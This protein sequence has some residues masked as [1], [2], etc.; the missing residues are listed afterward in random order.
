MPDTRRF[1][2]FDLGAESGRCVVATLSGGK[3]GLSEVHRFPT[4]S[5][6]H[7]DGLHWDI[8]AIASDIVAGL[9][10]A[11]REFGPDFAGI[12]ADTWGVDYVLLDS[13]GRVL[14][15]PYHYRDSRTDGIMDEAFAV[16][17]KGRLYGATGTQFAQFNTVFQ[18]LA[19][20]RRSPN[21]L[22]A[23]AT[24]L[25]MPDYLN[26][27][28][29]GEARAE[30]TIASTT[31][32]A[33]PTTRQWAWELIDS[34]SLPRAIFP[35]VVEPGTVLGA[36]R[37]DLAR[38]T[39]VNPGTPVIATAGHD[40]AS[41]VASIPASGD[42]WA[43]LSSGTWSLFGVE[44]PAPVMTDEAMRRDFTNE[45]GVG[46]TTRFLKNII[47]LWPIQECRRA[48]R[49]EGREFT[50][51]QLGDLARGEGSVGA[52][53][54]LNDPRFLKPGDMPRKIDSYLQETGQRRQENVGF[55]VGV[56]LESLAFSYRTAMKDLEAVTGRRI[57]RLHAVGG[58]IQNTLL[59]GMT[60]DA[61]GLP[62]LAGPVEGTIVG[63]IGMQAVATGAVAS[64]QAWRDIVSASFRLEQYGPAHTA[65][66]DE[67]EGRYLQAIGLA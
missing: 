20:R 41:A 22:D 31:G 5:V 1:I 37:P 43:Y 8:H 42:R 57:E 48:W 66:F 61:L 26:Y 46:G 64:P 54:D 19:E 30:Y 16:V 11:C 13:E 18:L 67:N 56:V 33:N 2:G 40:T 28:L 21:P 32:I 62:V 12:A 15:N 55:T 51:A 60:S 53:V 9:T 49:A 47:G 58:G 52:W 7:P 44:L 65:Y 14:G 24:M 35:A 29:S 45:G 10:R 34:F 23:A 25:L 63:N 6:Q 38:R 59:T 50:Y 36:I 4:H 39:G 3:I 17:P 27:L